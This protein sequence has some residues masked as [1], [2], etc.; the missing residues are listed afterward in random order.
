MTVDDNVF[1]TLTDMGINPTLA[2]A[3]AARFQHSEAAVEWCFGVGAD[4]S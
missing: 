1:G 3:A 4:V 2:R